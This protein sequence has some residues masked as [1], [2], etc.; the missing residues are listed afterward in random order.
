MPKPLLLLLALLVSM[1]A[2]GAAVAD[3]ALDNKI[4]EKIAELKKKLLKEQDQK[5]G[6][7]FGGGYDREPGPDGNKGDWVKNEGGPTAIALQAL[8]ASGESMQRE[9]IRKGINALRDEKLMR[10]IGTYATGVR[11]HVWSYLPEQPYVDLLRMDAQMVISGANTPSDSTYDYY[12]DYEYADKNKKNRWD[13]SATQYAILGLWQ[14]SK[15]G[16]SI[17]ASFWENAVKNFLEKQNA[18]GSW[19]YAARGQNNRPAMTLAGI[20][21]LYVAQQEIYRDRPTPANVTQA[22]NDGLANA[23]KKFKP[24]THVHGGEGY[25]QYSVER[26]GLA[27]GWRYI[28]DEDWFKSIAGA[29]LKDRGGGLVNNAFHLMF[30]A[31]GRVP[32]WVTKFATSEMSWNNHPNDIY[33]TNQHLSKKIEHEVN[34]QVVELHRPIREWFTPIAYLASDDTIRLTEK[35]QQQLRRYIDLG[36]LLLLNPDGNSS[37]FANSARQLGKRLFPEATWERLPSDHPIN[38]MVRHPHRPASASVLTN[39]VRDLM[40]LADG[41]WGSAMQRDRDLEQS[42]TLQYM[43]NLFAWATAR[44]DIPNRVVP[45]FPD[46]PDREPKDRIVVIRGRHSNQGEGGEPALWEPLADIL[47]NRANKGIEVRDLPLAVGGKPNPDVAA[48]EYDGRKVSLLH[49]IGVDGTT[50]LRDEELEAIQAFA[51]AGGT[52]LIETLGGEGTF[53]FTVQQQLRPLFGGVFPNQVKMTDPAYVPLV[54]GKGLGEGAVDTTD[55]ANFVFWRLQTASK[56]AF[57]VPGIRLMAWN[58]GDRPAV[59]ISPEDLSFGALGVR[60]ASILGYNIKSSR[61][62]L[63]NIL[64]QAEKTRMGN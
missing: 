36:G 51:N 39:G 37:V 2:N 5:T 12:V 29:I 4:E 31:R 49:I 62:L 55:E 18:D 22:I 56:S 25:Y 26:V 54:T 64:L 40:I 8:L 13:H 43:F 11:M 20:T 41:D 38:A 35:E 30:L 32:V 33:F 58:I 14:A 52:V 45:W 28:G 17:P 24:D 10:F 1:W 60:H 3:Q 27:G 47:A 57:Q 23:N 6:G 61:N 21:V 34:W 7:W 46:A 59:I 53:A 44:G 16:V 63:T 48:A 50:Q 19:P 15:R 9:E 42:D